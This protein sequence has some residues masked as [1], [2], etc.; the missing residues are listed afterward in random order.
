LVAR[1]ERRLRA[2]LEGGADARKRWRRA[3][4]R[5]RHGGRVI[6]AGDLDGRRPARHGPRRT[7]AEGARGRDRPTVA[8]GRDPVGRDASGNAAYRPTPRGGAAPPSERVAPVSERSGAGRPPDSAAGRLSTPRSNQRNWTAIAS[9]LRVRLRSAAA[10]EPLAMRVAQAE[11]RHGHIGSAA[12]WARNGARPRR[13]IPEAFV[14]VAHAEWVRAHA[15]AAAGATGVTSPLAPRGWHARR[16]AARCAPRADP[17]LPRRFLRHAEAHP[18]G[19]APATFA[20]VS[21]R[22]LD[23][24]TGLPADVRRH[25]AS[26][27]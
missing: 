2:S 15:Q 8:R 3:R 5:R 22:R 7:A 24:S 9:S 13:D 26:S 19:R 14:I 23:S 20:Q 6:A 21:P 10:R 12:D 4:A 25:L 18:D 27:G 1:L 16:R 11:H 17:P